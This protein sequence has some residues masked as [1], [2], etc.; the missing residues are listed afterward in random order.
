MTPRHALKKMVEEILGPQLE[1]YDLDDLLASLKA[2]GFA[3]VPREATEAMID[4]A[5][6]AASIDD[7]WDIEDA[8]SFSK[9]F[10]A[11]CEEPRNG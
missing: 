1:P 6:E 9:A 3:V 11:A 4:A 5:Y 10:K 7:H 2:S 8:W